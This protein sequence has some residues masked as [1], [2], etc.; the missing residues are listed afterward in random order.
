M[1]KWENSSKSNSSYHSSSDQKCGRDEGNDFEE[2]EFFWLAIGVATTLGFK[3][4]GGN[5]CEEI[6]FFESQAN[7]FRWI[8]LS[9]IGVVMLG[10]EG[11]EA[12]G[13]WV[14]DVFVF[15]LVN[16]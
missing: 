10:N 11:F 14:N 1:K 7:C 5:G 12:L 8:K 13:S 16:V 9:D 15:W 2:F 3:E 6:W 4:F